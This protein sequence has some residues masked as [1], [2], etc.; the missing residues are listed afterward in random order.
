MELG[1]I[2]W[3]KEEEFKAAKEKGLSFVEMDVN[4][5][6][7]EFFEH[8]DQVKLYSQ[9]YDLPVKAIGRWGINKI[10]EAGII[11]SEFQLECKLIDA[12]HEL[13]GDV[14]ITGCNYL[15]HLNFY[16]NCTLA[17][18]YLKKLVAYAK[19]KNVK[20]AI[21]TCRW[22]NFICTEE[23][24]NVI[25]NEVTDLYIKYDPSHS[26]YAGVDY[27]KEAMNWAHRFAHVH[28][29]G[30]LIIDGKRFDDPP[31]GLDQTDWPSFLSILYVRGYQGGLSIEPHSQLWKDELGER[32]VNYTIR[33]M[34][35][36]MI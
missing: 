29:K 12:L 36:L 27:L 1:I 5:R 26:I 9:K 23:S 21:Y 10:V 4:D 25:L 34:K 15:N 8:F 14:Y 32:G 11:D 2:A 22:N 35:N 6:D 31:A 16:Q 33:Y 17:I 3:I 28:I 20:I 24:W 7:A 30:T 19:E 13:G 18:Q